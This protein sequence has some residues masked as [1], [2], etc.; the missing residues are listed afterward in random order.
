[1]AGSG[2]DRVYEV[3]DVIMTMMFK[4]GAVL[5]SLTPEQRQLAQFPMDD[6]RRLDWDFIPKPDRAGVPLSDMTPHQ[7][8]LVHALLAASLSMRGYTQ[9]LQIMAMENVLREMQVSRM[10]I[11]AAELRSPDKYY[12]SVFGRPAFEDTWGWRLLGH[13]VS[14]SYTII[15]QRFLSV[16]PCNM[17]AEPIEAGV[18]SPLRRE[19]QLGFELLTGLSD[20]DRGRAVIHDV[21]PADYVTRQVAEVGEIEYP[22]YYDLGLLDYVLNDLDREKLK[23]VREEPAGLSAASLPDLQARV[24]MDL[25]DAYLGRMPDEVARQHRRRLDADGLDNVHFAW[26][27]GQ[28]PGTA[29][30]Y[31]VQTKDLLIEFDNAMNSGNH[32]HSVWR[33]LDNDL[34][35]DLLLDHYEREARNGN[36]LQTRLSSSVPAKPRPRQQ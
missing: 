25:V 5:W 18:L 27:G 21:A 29:H 8:S 20:A 30:Y 9:I 17:G 16:T 12:L 6:P 11:G 2:F 35:H 34:G 15:G 4:V 10:G 1:M 22:D 19:E 23:F 31:R 3:P 32:I 24:L 36:H 7:R 33:D 13:H 28:R 26:A 14:L